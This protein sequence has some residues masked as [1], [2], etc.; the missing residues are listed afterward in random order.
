MPPSNICTSC[1]T[2][3]Y[4]TLKKKL[5]KKREVFAKRNTDDICKENGEGV[6][7]DKTDCTKYFT[8]R[9]MNTAWSE[10]KHET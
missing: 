9:S 7:P 2:Q 5:K 4:K 8:C 6:W 10:K 3:E 1:P